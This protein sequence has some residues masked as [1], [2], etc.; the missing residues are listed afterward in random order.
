MPL[1]KKVR[2][3]SWSDLGASDSQLERRTSRNW[4]LIVAIF[5]LVTIGLAIAILALVRTRRATLWPWPGTELV[6]LGGLFLVI[7][8]LAAHLT[9]QRGQL[10]AMRRQLLRSQQETALK[11]KEHY[12]RP[13]TL[14]G[15]GPTLMSERNPQVV[16][17]RI[18]TIC[19]DFFD[20]QQVS[21]MLLDPAGQELEVQS[22]VGH[23]DPAHVLR[24]KQLVGNG[25]AGWVAENRQPLLI[26]PQDDL[27]RFK[28]LQP[29]VEPPSSVMAVPIVL[30]GELLGVLNLSTRSPEVVYDD[31]DL[32]AVQLFARNAGVF[33]RHV[34][35]S[36]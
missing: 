19:F 3:T 2:K 6:L 12:N 9:Y 10:V 26:R 23:G 32:R 11:M 8:L 36:E 16:F 34:E 5:L 15:I 33:I 21:L 27:T 13:M 14:Y 20:C 18:T 29:K 31:N 17:D 30:E 7:F 35:Q 28:G 4:W 22:A 24:A 25:I 1:S